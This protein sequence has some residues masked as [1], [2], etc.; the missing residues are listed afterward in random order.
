MRHLLIDNDDVEP[1]IARIESREGRVSIFDAGQFV[2]RSVENELQRKDHRGLV[3]DS[4][5]PKRSLF[6]VV[7]AL[8][9]SSVCTG[10]RGGPEGICKFKGTGTRFWPMGSNRIAP[11]FL[12]ML[13]SC[14]I[15]TPTI[16]ARPRATPTPASTNSR[17]PTARLIVQRAPN[18][19][20][21]L[22]IRLLIDG[23]KVSDVPRNQHY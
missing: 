20:T 8:K 6:A 11:I 16:E 7:H 1:L 13:I 3:V 17:Y 14:T 15:L 10:E 9:G 12:A 18:F 19:G 5:D 4:K 2:A 23:K 22:S 21:A